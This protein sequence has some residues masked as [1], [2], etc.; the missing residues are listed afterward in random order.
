MI[1]CRIS[2]KKQKYFKDIRIFAL[3]QRF[4]D[5]K[6]FCFFIVFLQREEPYY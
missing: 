1:A 3:Q 5:E 6:Y 4:G 2:I